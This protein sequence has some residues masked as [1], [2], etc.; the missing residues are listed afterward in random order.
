MHSLRSFL[1]AVYSNFLGNSPEWYK[2]LIAIFLVIN[3]LINEL[4]GPVV[5][6]W[7]LIFEFIFTLTMALRCYPLQPGRLLALEAVVILSDCSAS[8]PFGGGGGNWLNG[9]YFAHQS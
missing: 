8:L 4:M 3:P 1:P 7:V 5:S 2:N 6:G 9:D